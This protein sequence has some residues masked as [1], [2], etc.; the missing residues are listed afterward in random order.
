MD[1]EN[2]ANSGNPVFHGDVRP[3]KASCGAG[4]RIS[5]IVFPYYLRTIEWPLRGHCEDAKGEG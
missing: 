3:A 4:I 5:Y 1:E 2:F